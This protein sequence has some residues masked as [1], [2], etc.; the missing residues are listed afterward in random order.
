MVA[1]AQLSDMLSDLRAEIGHSTNIV[2][3]IND[4]DTLL[5]YLNRTQVRLYQEYDWPQ[6]IVHRDTPLSPGQ[7]FY[8]YPTDL[9]FDD[10]TNVW[11]FAPGPLNEVFYGIGPREMAFSNPQLGQQSW[12]TRRWMHNPDQA[13]FEVWPVPDGSAATIAPFLRMWGTKTVAKMVNDSDLSTL[14]VNLI[15]L[16]SAAEL[17]ARDGAK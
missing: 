16:F 15:V 14:P 3:G 11:L 2:H 9:A 12:P 1:Q 7:Q 6:L 10:I 17:L 5:Y 4:R 8:V 13:M